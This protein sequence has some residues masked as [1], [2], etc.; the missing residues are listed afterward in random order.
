MAKVIRDAPPL[1][2]KYEFAQVWKKTQHQTY[3]FVEGFLF[4]PDYPEVV[5]K[6]PT[7]QFLALNDS[8]VFPVLL[9]DSVVRSLTIKRGSDRVWDRKLLARSHRLRVFYRTV[10]GYP[11]LLLAAVNVNCNLTDD[12][13]ID[14]FIVRGDLIRWDD[15]AN[16]LTTMEIRQFR[17]RDEPDK[18]AFRVVLHGKLDDPIAKVRRI[19]GQFW[20]VIA[21]RR[22]IHL[23]VIESAL[24][25]QPMTPPKKKTLQRKVFSMSEGRWVLP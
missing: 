3:G 1:W 11:G 24:R 22:G 10:Q 9:T 14:R 21:E 19:K 12:S 2:R 25:S 15:G 6:D 16:P 5:P 17:L 13:L 4:F 20:E 23:H 18:G 8:V 7:G